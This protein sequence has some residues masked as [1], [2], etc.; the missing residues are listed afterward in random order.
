MRSTLIDWVLYWNGLKKLFMPLW[1]C[2]F[3]D[4]AQLLLKP[5]FTYIYALT[6]KLINLFH[7]CFQLIMCKWDQKSNKCMWERSWWK[8]RIRVTWFLYFLQLLTFLKI[9]GCQP[10]SVLQCFFIDCES[11][12]CLGHLGCRAAFSEVWYIA[13]Q[14]R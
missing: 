7:C 1:H 12:Q 14:S 9:C 6:S 5:T 2:Q 8:F 3:L 10:F 4:R 11:Y 13:I